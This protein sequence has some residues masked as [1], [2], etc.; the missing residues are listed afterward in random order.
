MFINV[1]G[2][3]ALLAILLIKIHALVFLHKYP[4]GEFKELQ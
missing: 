3:F 4:D 2:F 1:Y